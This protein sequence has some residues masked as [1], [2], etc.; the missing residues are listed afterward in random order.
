MFASLLITINSKCYR[1]IS[2]D[3]KFW[4]LQWQ[5][6]RQ[7]LKDWDAHYLDYWE[8]KGVIKSEAEKE[9]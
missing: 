5:F 8:K 3:G 1:L 2:S 4:V 6:E 7:E 9:T